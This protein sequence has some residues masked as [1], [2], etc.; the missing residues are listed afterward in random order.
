[1]KTLG[2][3][4]RYSI[5]CDR[6]SFAYQKVDTCFSSANFKLGEHEKAVLLSG[7]HRGKTSLIR[8]LSG[9]ESGYIGNISI[10]GMKGSNIKNAYKNVVYIPEKPVLFENKTVSDNIEYAYNVL[11]ENSN[12]MDYIA[13]LPDSV[14]SISNVKAKKLDGYN[15]TLLEV[16]RAMLKNIKL[17]L[18]D[19]SINDICDKCKKSGIDRDKYLSEVKPLYKKL[20]DSSESA[21][22]VCESIDEIEYY[23]MKDAVIFYIYLGKIYRF[24]NYQ[25]FVN[26]LLELEAL[27]YINNANK[28]LVKLSCENDNYFLYVTKFSSFEELNNYVLINN[29][30]RKNIFKNMKKHTKNVENVE[31]NA[32]FDN[33]FIEK[34]PLDKYPKFIEILKNNDVI[35]EEYFIFFSHQKRKNNSVDLGKK[36]FSLYLCSTGERIV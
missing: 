1:V 28:K 13:K 32:N 30:K 25:D 9:L 20:I 17:L 2:K 34:I 14:Q 27:Y 29:K 19:R 15:K 31:N 21:L 22:V 10:L 3:D 23:E 8:I 35:N 5:E 16:E 7:T 24:E 6:L 18:L 36:N 11:Y 4:K 26:N 33:L 12:N